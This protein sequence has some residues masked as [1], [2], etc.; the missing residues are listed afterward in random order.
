MSASRP[1]PMTGL[2]TDGLRRK[3]TNKILSL[4]I[5]YYVSKEKFARKS[6]DHPLAKA[7]INKTRLISQN[8]C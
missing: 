2:Y 7:L 6:Q 8:G 5:F 3:V 4:Q 1:K